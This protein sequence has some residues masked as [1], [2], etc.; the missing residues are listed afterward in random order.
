MSFVGPTTLEG[1]RGFPVERR[2]AEA[3]PVPAFIETDSAAAALGERLHGV[4]RTFSDFFFLYFGL[5]LG[6]CMVHDGV[7]VRGAFR[8]AGEIGHVPLVPGG[9]PCACGNDGC[10][11]RYVSLEAYYR[12]EPVI[13]RAG[14][15]AEAA[16][17]LRRAIGTIENLFDP[18]TIIVSG[19]GEDA[20]L[21]DLV[22][23]AEPLANSVSNRKARP[24]PRIIRSANGHDAVLRGAAALALSGMLSPRHRVAVRSR[25]AIFRRK[26]GGMSEALLKLEN[27]TR[28]FGAIEALRGISFEVKRGEVVA[29]LG[30]N[31]AGKSTLVKIIAGGLA[32]ILRQADVRGPRAFISRRPPK[33]RPRASRRSIRTCRC[34]PMSMSSPISSWAA[35]S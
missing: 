26:A 6:G 9:E 2:L 4:G 14:W 28:N 32:A 33:P 17:V 27:I 5:G 10:V 15:I 3:S 1:W 21:T 25:I 30:D 8:N 29:L 35:R 11:E 12:R 23:A 31:G 13:G 22:A 18:Q 19:I 34:A 24:V 20:L 16:P 7:A